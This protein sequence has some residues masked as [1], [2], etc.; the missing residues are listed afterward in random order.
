MKVLKKRWPKRK[1]EK[2]IGFYL[3]ATCPENSIDF[4]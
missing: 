4:S 2:K 3:N 1:E